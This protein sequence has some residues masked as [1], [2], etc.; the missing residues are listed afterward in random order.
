M[1]A[2]D[3]IA[4]G[5]AVLDGYV[6]AAGAT[7]SCH[8][9]RDIWSYRLQVAYGSKQTE[10]VLSAEFLMDLPGTP[11]HKRHVQDYLPSILTRLQNAEP[12][13]YL[14]KTGIPFAL[15]LRWPFHAHPSRDVIWCH[16]D[17]EDARSPGLVAKT[18]LVIFG[19]LDEAEFRFRPFAR[20]EAVVNAVRSSLDR[21]EVRFFGRN[22]HPP[23]T[24][25]INILEKSGF[26]RV[27]VESLE[28]FIRAKVF[29]L[30]FSQGDQSTKVWIADPWDA[31]YLGV[32]PKELIRTA[33]ILQARGLLVLAPDGQFASAGDVLLQ[34][35]PVSNNRRAG[36][37][38]RAPS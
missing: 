4:Q 24:Q 27:P 5:I 1:Q 26:P 28:Q 22:E 29:W 6:R 38:L 37:G 30:A 18:A 31:A 36:I 33:Q 8:N 12:D 17:V 19:G 10:F 7:L 21:G 25:E 2:Q 15:R 13:D 16:A 9:L 11:D 34:S 32:S 14:S 35:P 23:E 3:E 20:I